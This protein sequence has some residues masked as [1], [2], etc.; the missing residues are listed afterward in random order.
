MRNRSRR[1]N[2]KTINDALKLLH[3]DVREAVAIASEYLTARGVDHALI[4][5]IAVNAHGYTVNTTDV[6]FLIR[7]TAFFS[8][9]SRL[10]AIPPGPTEYRGKVMNVRIDY[11]SGETYPELPAL[12]DFAGMPADGE[13]PYLELFPLLAMKLLAYRPKDQA[14]VI[15]LISAGAVDVGAFRDWC[16]RNA[17][18]MVVERFD[19]LVLRADEEDR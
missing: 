8:G 13:V 2:P 3:P 10:I 9:K 12:E 14:H 1:H 15:G 19:G 7:D 5:G 4:G 11:L 16:V 6:D 18:A 17:T